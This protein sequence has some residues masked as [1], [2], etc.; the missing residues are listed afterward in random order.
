M[1]FYNS[2]INWLVYEEHSHSFLN[3]L[4]PAVAELQ[5]HRLNNCLE[6]RGVLNETYHTALSQAEGIFYP[7]YLAMCGK[8]EH[9]SGVRASKNVL[10]QYDR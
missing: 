5:P 7:Q 1:S 2:F 10:Q 8:I 9:T 3:M 6:L 4:Q